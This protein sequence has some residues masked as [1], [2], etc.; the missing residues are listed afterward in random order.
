MGKDK[1]AK[2]TKEQKKQ[3]ELYRTHVI[4]AVE[5]LRRAPLSGS[6]KR[7]L[8]KKDFLPNELR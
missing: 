5:Q 7:F 4:T 1:P 8:T 3:R 6:E 2:L